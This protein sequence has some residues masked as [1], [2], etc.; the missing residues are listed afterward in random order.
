MLKL[1][2]FIV[3]VISQA[4]LADTPAPKNVSSQLTFQGSPITATQIGPVLGLDCNIANSSLAPIPVQYMVS[5]FP[6]DPRDIR[7][8]TSSDQLSCGQFGTWNINNISGTVS[9][10]TGASTSANQVT[11]NSNLS[12]I[13]GKLNSLGQKTMSGSV[14][15]VLP[16]DQSITVSLPSGISTSGLQVVGNTS[17]NSI[18]TKVTSFDLDSSAGS[19]N[20]TGVSLRT[21]ASGGSVEA[22]T[23]SNPLRVDVTGST[24]QPVSVTSL[25]LPTG[26][27]TSANQTTANSSLGSINGKLNSLGQ[28]TSINSTPVVL[29]SD[30]STIPVSQSG[31]WN[32]NVVSGS[33]TLPTGA[34]T[35]VKQDTGNSS[36][37]SIDS[38]TRSPG[39]TTMLASTPVVIANDQSP[40]PVTGSITVTNPSVGL[41]GDLAPTS[42]T[43]AGGQDNLGNLRGLTTS[44]TGLLKIDGSDAT[45]PVSAASLPLPT[46]ASTSSLQST[47]NSTL[48]TING[49]VLTYDTDS[50]AGGEFTPGVVLRKSANGGS[51][52]LGTSSNPIRIDTTGATNQPVS[53][54]SLPLPTGAS[55]ALKQD[56]GNTSLAAIDTK[57]TTTANG[58]KVDNSAV[59]QPVSASA[60][61]LPTGASTASNQTTG[62]STLSSIDTKINSLAT[63]SKQ[64]TGNTTLTLI[65][66]KTPSLGQTTMSASSPVVISSNQTSLPVTVGN[67]PATQ[68]V[69]VVSLPLPS[70]AATAS[71]QTT[72]NSSLATLVGNSDVASS[73][74]ASEST[75][76]SISSKLPATLGQKTSVGS[77]SV[78]VSSDQSPLP[79]SISS[80]PGA[81][82]SANQ[83]TEIGHLTSID[84]QLNDQATAS[85][86][87]TANSSLFSIDGKIT[88]VDT[89]SVTVISSALPTGAATESTLSNI[90]SKITTI[91]TSAVVVSS[92]VLPTGASTS[93]L[94]STGNTSLNS[95]DTKVSTATNQTTGNI[96]L[97]SIDSKLSTTNSTVGS[98]NTVQTDGTQK[99]QITDGS[100]SASITASAPVGTEQALVVRNIPSGTQT[101]SGAVTQSGSWSTGRTWTLSNSSDSIAAIQSGTWNINNISGTVSLPTGAS[102]ESTL[103]SL[104]SKVTSVNTGAVVVSSSALPTGAATSANQTTANSSLSTIS[105]QLPSTLGQATMS[106]GLAVTIASDQSAFP[107]TANIGTTGG[108]A[109]DSTVSTGN[110]SLS[111]ID[112]KT[113]TVN[114]NLGTINTSLGT[115]NTS[116]GTSQPRKL[117]DGSG[118]A[119][120]SQVSGSQRPLDVGIN[121]AGVQVDPR[122]RSWNLS[123][124]TDSNTATQG[125]A[126]ITSGAW[127]IKLTDGTNVTAV[128]A[129][130]TAAIAS[131]PSSVVALSPNSPIPTGSNTIGSVSNISGTVS[132]PTGAS[133]SSL[134]TSGNSSLS[135]IDSKLNSLGQKTMSGSVPVTLSSDQ[136]S[137]PVAATQS[138]T[139]NVTNISGTVSLPTGAATESTLSSLNG[140]VTAVNTGAVVVSSSALPTGAST[141][142]LQ[143]TGNTTLATISGQLPATL[144]Q[145]TMANS[146][147]VVLASDQASIPV[148]AA[149]SGIWKHQVVDSSNNSV[150]TLPNGDGTYSLQVAQSATNFLYSSGNSSVAQ[151]GAGATFTGSIDNIISQQAYSILLTTDQPGSLTVKQ[152]IDSSCTRVAQSLIYSVTAGVGFSRSGTT[153]GN[154][155][156]LVFTNSGLS[157]TTTLNINTYYG[158]LP[159][160]TQLNN[161]PV[162]LN[163]VSGTALNLG[164][165]TMSASIPVAISSNQ[166][167]IPSSQSGTW[168]VNNVSGTVSLP[169]GAATSAI[170]TTNGASLTSIDSKTPSLGQNTQSASQPTIQPGDLT[171]SVLNITVL[172]SGST[173][174]TQ[175][176]NQ[177]IITG[178]ATAGST[179]SATTLGYNTGVVKLSG[180]WTGSIQLEVSSDGGTS[181]IPLPSHQV[182]GS[183]FTLA[184][185]ANVQAAFNLNSKTNVRM[186]ANGAV[187]GTANVQ[188]ILSYNS[189]GIVFVNNALRI[190]DGANSSVATPLTVLAASTAATTTNTSAVVA[191]SPN[192]PLS[193]IT[194]T[195]TASNQAKGRVDC[196]AITGTY[197]TVLTPG[198]NVSLLHIFNSCNGTI[199]ISINGGTTDYLELEAGEST[200]L[201]LKS[202][203]LF[204]G[205]GVNIQAKDGAVNPITGSLR[206]SAAG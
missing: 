131:D 36:L 99:S 42:A 20:V 138:G 74:R 15:V 40:I 136:T 111:S 200:V 148:A 78:V 67:F 157:T 159:A 80:A 120:T 127:P 62:N 109:L 204:L 119:I 134:Q 18:D 39:Q 104:N 188:F 37:S 86:Q 8:L 43:L 54:T 203:S 102:T 178:S 1:L 197:A 110:S 193:A 112:S 12:T 169:T 44:S 129:A 128:K 41:T 22:G 68:P 122:T 9:L 77:V 196:S 170:Q 101:I 135:S 114:T 97:S 33:V 70:G 73:T 189:S 108:L 32:I 51:V 150:G 155:L 176:N 179:A 187:T 166:S 46:G 191:L 11:T 71:L 21:S 206:I 90:N 164:Q 100:N 125:P 183:I 13:S 4:A 31:T 158:T 64:D 140:K 184:Y 198:F 106:N 65:N 199:I 6:V 205:S 23:Q 52:E 57:L 202:N 49:K 66:N 87:S 190:T 5:G 75:V 81:A 92:S 3:L 146:Q 172:D 151:L 60:L 35:A 115:V 124:G 83:V 147:G 47:T 7:P 113:T 2:F 126:A 123:A 48:S 98:I 24:T 144:G 185:S 156:Q 34:S 27:A 79:V 154:Y 53:A 72:G 107:V 94:Q 180:T 149:Q 59:T 177:G 17:L 192:S 45:Q 195:A 16:S 132:L 175:S 28:K 63:S 95:I 121:V 84:T 133:T 130:S 89:D 181:W 10:P 19:Q 167:A 93:S 55:T 103:S 61:P 160:T 69:S 29:S 139:W 38:K 171:S 91:D 186:R 153:N 182:G 162:A 173:V 30:Q 142:S 168:N 117:Q 116:I 58:L 96:S 163:E 145:K 118:N 165:T 56:A 76:S 85:N 143:T 82:T 25:P 152:C 26:A 201:D 88:S 141:S 50:G 194:G 105:S 137:I 14:P 161:G 174:G